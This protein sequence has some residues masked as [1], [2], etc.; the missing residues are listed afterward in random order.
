MHEVVA[1]RGGNGGQDGR[2]ESPVKPQMDKAAAVVRMCSARRRR[3][4]DHVADG[5]AHT[6]LYFPELSKLTQTWKLK[7]DALPC[8][9]NSQFLHV[10]ILGHDENFSQL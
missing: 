8:S 1:E 9:K 3:C 7:I 10:D 5:W 2:R 6:V 4:S